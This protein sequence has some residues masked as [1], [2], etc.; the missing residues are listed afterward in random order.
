MNS[1]T[2][3][4]ANGQGGA[5][6]PP[7]ATPI[8]EGGQGQTFVAVPAEDG[9]SA[10]PFI[11][12]SPAAGDAGGFMP[13]EDMPSSGAG[14]DELGAMLGGMAGGVPASVTGDW[15]GKAALTGM[16]GGT[17]GTS[18]AAA[19]GAV[20]MANPMAQGMLSSA[21]GQFAK[22]GSGP[23]GLLSG[24]LAGGAQ[25]AANALGQKAIGGLLDTLGLGDVSKTLA[26]LAT[27][28]AGDIA[29]VLASGGCFGG[30][31]QAADAVNSIAPGGCTNPT[32]S[33]GANNANKTSAITEK[34]LDKAADKLLDQWK[35]DDESSAA[36][37]VAH[38]AVN[39]NKD[40]I[41][42]AAK[43]PKGTIA[44]I[45]GFFSGESSD[46]FLPAARILDPDL[47]VPELIKQGVAN[48]KVEGL[49][50]SRMTDPLMPSAPAILEG[51][52]TV[53]AA[54]KE[55]ARLT[56]KTAAPGVMLVKG[57]P[58]VLV[59]G[60]S[61]F[62]A[63]PPSPTNAN[64]SGNGSP[65]GP[66][67]PKSA[68][69]GSGGSGQAGAGGG[70][71][72]QGGGSNVG[73]T[74]MQGQSTEQQQ[75]IGEI[76]NLPPGAAPDPHA[77]PASNPFKFNDRDNGEVRGWDPDRGMSTTKPEYDWLPDLPGGV[78]DLLEAKDGESGWFGNAYTPGNWYLL[79]GLIELG[80]P[81]WPGAGNGVMW[82]IPD[83]IFGMDMSDY[84]LYHD[85]KFHP[86]DSAHAFEPWKIFTEWEIPSF[87]TGM[88]A[89][90][91]NSVH[92]GLQI[93][94]SGVTTAVSLGTWSATMAGELAKKF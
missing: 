62:V 83:K 49:P 55:V 26:G 25:G 54:N 33:G 71:A 24:A 37:Q 82:Y 34:A 10:L 93:I 68:S 45:K 11:K 46:A 39:D 84:Y 74:G 70:Q 15:L 88:Q 90:G 86:S 78:R 87:I 50:I 18:T 1:Y 73:N 20:G 59:G 36:E 77:D 43:D 61:A 14:G 31:Q 91:G 48:I 75:Q 41:K 89:A 57:A 6:P 7:M 56:S 79:G 81:V 4:L 44:K 47:T 5:F 27:G 17:P 92:Q 76:D 22:G 21:L 8:Y 40:A 28:P 80:S 3:M 72:G 58:S 51:A 30:M 23:L 35:V 65:A 66:T 63:P 67:A 19:L 2:A 94:Y 16:L 52:A 13:V 69:S 85:W 42:A 32:G 64:T 29:D 38:K 9:V 12:G 53:L 60:G